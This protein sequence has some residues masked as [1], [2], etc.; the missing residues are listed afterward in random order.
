MGT[1]RV[2]NS[3]GAKQRD[4]RMT[5]PLGRYGTTDDIANT[6]IF[7]ASPAGSFI[8]GTHIVV[9]GLQWQAGGVAPLMKAKP[10]IRNAM[11]KEREA[12]AKGSGGTHGAGVQTGQKSKL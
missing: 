10:F 5:V 3:A 11:K 9:D 8:T 6:A 2:F 1:G 4:V 7:L 12:R